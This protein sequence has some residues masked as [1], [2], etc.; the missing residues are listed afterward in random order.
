MEQDCILSCFS[1]HFQIEGNW[2][3]NNSKINTMYL[4]KIQ[5]DFWIELSN[6]TLLVA[7]EQAHLWVTRASDL[8]AAAAPACNPKVSLLAGYFKETRGWFQLMKFLWL[9]KIKKKN[10][11]GVVRLPRVHRLTEALFTRTW[12]H[13]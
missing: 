2:P 12:F 5:N 3:E 9:R 6:N 1:D 11:S 10:A 13:L 4:K 7:S 8:R